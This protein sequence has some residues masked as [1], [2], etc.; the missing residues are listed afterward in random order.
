V[1]WN[2]AR[3][4]T[5]SRPPAPEFGPGNTRATIT[6]GDVH[7]RPPRGNPAGYEKPVPSK[8]AFVESTP[9]STT[10]ILI[11]VPSAPMTRWSTSAPIRDGARFN[12]CVY[13]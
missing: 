2:D 11:P 6:F 3:G 7:F 8:N 13:V 1:P 5:A 4:S 10:P 9:S 12:S